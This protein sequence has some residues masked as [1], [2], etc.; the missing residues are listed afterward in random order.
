MKYKRQNS[1]ITHSKRIFKITNTYVSVKLVLD[2]TGVRTSRDLTLLRNVNCPD[3][4]EME[5]IHPFAYLVSAA[6]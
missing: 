5:L 2:V 1:S 3:S 6:S 4:N